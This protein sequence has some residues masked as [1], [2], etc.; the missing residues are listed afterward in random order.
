MAVPFSAGV[1]GVARDA[2][3]PHDEGGG[4]QGLLRLGA[5]AQQRHHSGR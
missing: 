5:Q 1:D 4:H 3:Q 2:N